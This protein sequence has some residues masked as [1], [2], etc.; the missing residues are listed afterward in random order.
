MK[1]LLNPFLIFGYHSPAYF[2]NR[3]NETAEIIQALNNNRNLTLIAPRRIGK[4]G[5]IHHVFHKLSQQNYGALIY[6]DIFPT[7]N[8][9]DFT[10]LFAE[11]ILGSLDSDIQKSLKRIGSVIKS[12]RPVVRFDPLTG[13]PEISVDISPGTEEATLKDVFLY[14]SASKKRCVIAIDEFQQI[15]E[16]PEKNIEALLRSYIQFIPNVSFIF[17][18]SK[19]HIMQELF[20]SVKRPFYQSTQLLNIGVIDKAEY[21]SFANSFFQKKKL[22][23]K[24]DVFNELYDIFEGYTWYIQAVLNRLYGY[25]ECVTSNHQFL[26]AVD[27]LISEYEHAFQNLLAAYTKTEV[28]LL[29]AIAKEGLVKMINAGRFISKYDLKAASSVNTALEKLLKRELVYRSEEGYIV[30]DR[31]MSIWLERL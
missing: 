3:N 26:K 11:A 8:L 23:F 31:L 12:F 1:S 30:Y 2:C 5:L 10:S 18:G 13:L 24:E 9:N 17:S 28:K 7:T 15:T 4:T 14:L 21:Y 19:Q 6:L 20:V 16:Y 27:L 25:G 29:K 22:R